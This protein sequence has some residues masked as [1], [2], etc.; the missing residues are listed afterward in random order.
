MA[1]KL[2]I[3]NRFY[4]CQGWSIHSRGHYCQK[5]RPRLGGVVMNNSWF[6]LL[7]PASCS[8]SLCVGMFMHEAF[9]I[10]LWRAQIFRVDT[11]RDESNFHVQLSLLRKHKRWRDVRQT[12]WI[13]HSRGE[14]RT[15]GPNKE[16]IS[17]ANYKQSGYDSPWIKFRWIQ[18]GK[19]EMR[20]FYA[21]FIDF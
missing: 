2:P 19:D 8:F 12:R 13:K 5:K 15:S 9:I 20:V 4:S 10:E 6:F 7:W 1:W 17:W 3:N 11:Q 14:Q 18:P 21:G 16:R